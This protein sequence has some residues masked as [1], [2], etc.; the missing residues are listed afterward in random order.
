MNDFSATRNLEPP[1]W[2]RNTVSNGLYLN[3]SEHR[4]R[5]TTVPTMVDVTPEDLQG[6]LGR[7][8]LPIALDEPIADNS[9][10]DLRKV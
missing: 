8:P 2:E 3:R 6:E 7:N 10:D 5:T 9:L 1:I 4:S